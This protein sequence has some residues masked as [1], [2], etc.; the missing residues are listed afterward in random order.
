MLTNGYLSSS[1]FLF[2]ILVTAFSSY[3]QIDPFLPRFFFPIFISLTYLPPLTSLIDFSSFLFFSLYS[4]CCSSTSS[5]QGSP[6]KILHLHLPT[7]CVFSSYTHH[8]RVLLQWVGDFDFFLYSP[9]SFLVGLCS[10]SCLALLDT[11]HALVFL[12]ILSF[13]ICT[14]FHQHD[15]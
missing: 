1:S 4:S 14:L 5:H 15:Y 3:M 7:C 11:F 10:I 13:L 2:F 8:P 12:S 9:F 6:Q